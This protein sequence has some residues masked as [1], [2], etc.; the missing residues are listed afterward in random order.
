M[1]LLINASN[2][3]VGGGVQVAVSLI[4]E[5]VF[6]GVEFKAAISPKVHEQLNETEL[7]KCILIEKSPSGIFNFKIRRLLDDIVKENQIDKVLT[8]F[9]P[10]YW[11]PKNVKHIVGYALP[12]LIYDISKIYPELS[13]R[14]K[15]KFQILR[16]IQ[17]YFYKKN[18][19]VIITETEDVNLRVRHLLGYPDENV[20]TISNTLN[21]KMTDADICDSS[22]SQ[23]FPV[24]KEEDI[25][26]LTI[27]H[28]YP[29]KNLK[30][31]KSLLNKLPENYKFILTVNHDFLLDIPPEMHHRVFCIGFARLNQCAYLYEY[32]D[33]VFLPTVLECF[34]ASYLESMYFNKFILTSDLPF[35]RT[36]CG[37]SA[38]YFNP[39]NENDIALVIQSVFSDVK[40]R[41]ILLE[42]MRKQLSLYPTPNERAR[43]YIAQL[44]KL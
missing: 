8:I 35:A 4:Q 43:Q 29:H 9:G 36:I 10:S 32:C 13:V 11:S 37:D 42:K 25:Y 19:D 22:L 33:A 14:E 41:V 7:K 1:N 39:Y 6:N 18:A 21:K 28:N 17:P 38:A 2:L 30:V 15:I 12:W 20:V 5:L 40:V 3:Y 23:F 16:V 26:L 44:D 34:S 24:K 31:I 27:S